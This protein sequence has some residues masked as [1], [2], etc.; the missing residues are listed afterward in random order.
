MDVIGPFIVTERPVTKETRNMKKF[1]VW[2]LIASDSQTRML[3]SASMESQSEVS[4][5]EALNSIFT[6]TGYPKQVVTD[7]SS[8]VVSFKQKTTDGWAQGINVETTQEE[9]CQ[10]TINSDIMK[11]MTHKIAKLDINF[12]TNTPK[13]PW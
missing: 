8:Q 6:E 7:S 4:Y 3:Y 2:E 1:K 9:E 11:R 10:D 12:I 13:A 5:T